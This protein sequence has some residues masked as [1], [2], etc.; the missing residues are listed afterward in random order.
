MAGVPLVTVPIVNTDPDVEQPVATNA[1]VL[2]R[3]I[4]N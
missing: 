2:A 1:E 3:D 4:A